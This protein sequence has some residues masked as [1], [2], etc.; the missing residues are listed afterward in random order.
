MD[1]LPCIKKLEYI[2]VMDFAT[3]DEGWVTSGEKHQ[4]H[5]L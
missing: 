2:E 3:V 5:S 1:A 4:C